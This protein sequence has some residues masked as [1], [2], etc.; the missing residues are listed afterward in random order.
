VK[1]GKKEREKE[2]EREKRKQE[3]YKAKQTSFLERSL[4]CFQFS[5]MFTGIM[6]QYSLLD[7]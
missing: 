7:R 6:V 4:K 3:R 5:R 2:R 1:D